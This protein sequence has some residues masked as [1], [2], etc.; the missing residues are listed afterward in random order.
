MVLWLFLPDWGVGSMFTVWS[1]CRCRNHT[2]KRRKLHPILQG[3]SPGDTSFLYVSSPWTAP[4][5]WLS[6][7][8]V[9][10]KEPVQINI[11]D[12]L[13]ENKEGHTLLDN[14]G[15]ATYP[16]SPAPK[17]RPNDC[18]LNMRNCDFN[19]HFVA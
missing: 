5:L 4:S 3:H 7:C 1:S 16:F 9:A 6:R 13:I 15:F 18:N 14:W 17:K 12:Y 10:R 2:I 19:L 8:L 11:G